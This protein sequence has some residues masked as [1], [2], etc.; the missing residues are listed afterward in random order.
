MNPLDIILTAS[1]LTAGLFGKY[2]GFNMQFNKL[3]SILLSI[4]ITKVI[5]IELIIFFIPYIGLSAQTKPIVYF[6]S[7]TI[8]YFVLRFVFNFIQSNLENLHK[9][10][11]I[12]STL[13]I[14][15]GLI[16]GIIF[17]SIF[18]SIIFYSFKINDN[19]TERLKKSALFNSIYITKTVLVD[20]GE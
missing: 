19:T 12:D 18:I 6:M 3:I 8:I 7:I 5:F 10:K 15:V 11:L 2:S 17:I 1:I 13:G 14:I 4:L 9:N 16:N 20:Y